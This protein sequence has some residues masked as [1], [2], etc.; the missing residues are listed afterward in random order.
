MDGKPGGDD[1]IKVL[2]AILG[3]VGVLGG[4]L[5]GILPQIIP[6]TPTQTVTPATSTSTATLVPTITWTGVPSPMALPVVTQ[7]S[8]V[9]STP[10]PTPVS[11]LAPGQ[12]WLSNCISGLWI[13][14]PNTGFLLD[15]QN[16]WQQPL[17]GFATTGGILSIRSTQTVRTA[18]LYGMLLPLEQETS[19]SIDLA[20]VP[21]FV[22]SQLWVGIIDGTAFRTGIIVIY[23]ADENL[24]REIKPGA[25]YLMSNDE[26]IIQSNR[27]GLTFDLDRNEISIPVNIGYAFNTAVEYRDPHLFIGYLLLPGNSQPNLNVRLSNLQITP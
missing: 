11:F 9:T 12:D 3:L 5:I 23:S 15:D 21:N 25:S 13:P 24:I 8:V 2:I 16:C 14:Y 19:V 1:K 18:N 22:Q 10:S 27:Y 4:A 6:P 17:L 26:Q 20:S 7:T